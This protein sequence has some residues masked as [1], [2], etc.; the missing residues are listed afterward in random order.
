MSSRTD[1]DDA[2]ANSEGD[3]SR[4][5][6]RRRLDDQRS[7]IPTDHQ[8]QRSSSRRPPPHDG[9][10]YLPTNYMAPYSSTPRRVGDLAFADSPTGS[11]VS[12]PFEFGSRHTSVVSAQSVRDP[13]LHAALG[14]TDERSRPAGSQ[15]MKAY[16]DIVQKI[17]VLEGNFRTYG[18]S[19]RMAIEFCW[20]ELVKLITAYY[21]DYDT[22]TSVLYTELYYSNKLLGSGTIGNAGEFRVAV[23]RMLTL[24]REQVDDE[25]DSDKVEVRFAIRL[26]CSATDVYQ[27]FA[28]CPAGAAG[29][30]HPESSAAGG[31]RADDAG[32]G[33]PAI[34][35]APTTVPSGPAG[36]GEQRGSDEAA[37][38]EGPTVSTGRSGGGDSDSN[39]S[40]DV[41]IVSS[42]SIGPASGDNKVQALITDNRDDWKD[43][44]PTCEF[45]GHDPLKKDGNKGQGAWLPG[46]KYS[47]RPNQMIDVFNYY[48]RATT[49]E[50]SPEGSVLAHD[51]GVGK[52]VLYLA[53]IAVRRLVLLSRKHA[54]QFP[55]LHASEDGRCAMTG[56]PFGMQCACEKDGLSEA[57]AGLSSVG[58]NMLMVPAALVPQAVRCGDAFLEARVSFQLPTGETE[59][60][61]FLRTV[62]WAKSRPGD[63]AIESIR[64]RFVFVPDAADDL[65]AATATRVPYSEDAGQ[66]LLKKAGT[67]VRLGARREPLQI[68]STII[69]TIGRQRVSLDK[70]WRNRWSDQV[71]LRVA[72]KEARAVIQYLATYYF[73]LIVWDE[74]HQVRDTDS[75]LASVLFEITRRQQRRPLT[76]AATG[77]PFV[78]SLA[79]GTLM[80]AWTKG[81]HRKREVDGLRAQLRAA[82]SALSS[83][84]FEEAK[85]LAAPLMRGVMRRTA[86]STCLGH[87]IMIRQ[88]VT[89]ET[90]D[91]PVDAV[92]APA[93]A[94]LTT[95]V[96]RKYSKK[97]EAL[98][99]AK[100]SAV[101]IQ[102]VTS[103][104]KM[105]MDED[106]RTLDLII[107]VPGL[108]Q[109]TLDA[110][111]AG[112]PIKTTVAS[113]V[114]AIKSDKAK[115]GKGDVPRAYLKDGAVP[116]AIMTQLDTMLADCSRF[117]ALRDVCYKAYKDTQAYPEDGEAWSGFAGPKNVLI[118]TTWPFV[119]FMLQLWV[120]RNLDP[121]RFQSGLLHSGMK[122]SERLDV[123]DWFGVFADD[124]GEP[125]AKT[126]ILITTYKLGGTGLDTLKVANHLVHY[127]VHKNINDVSQ[128]S[129]R[130]DRQGQQLHSTIYFL[131]SQE[132]P[133]DQLATTVA[134]SRTG[135]F[136]AHGLVGRLASWSDEA[137]TA[138]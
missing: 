80:L 105:D 7:G 51:M 36:V 129:G 18:A 83:K 40:D 70:S 130:I 25:Q 6:S 3:Q 111:A 94:A 93:V 119:A 11:S 109:A 34:L 113:F 127:G 82:N 47:L 27:Y 137:D 56:R 121:G 78:T 32:D 77:S 117:R 23:G 134:D 19:Q 41:E 74:A 14:F 37:A 35:P 99:A 60:A 96:G 123:T 66:Q 52:T 104:T 43:W 110:T 89:E 44:P 101:D 122:E 13:L 72:E 57:I 69:L 21:P 75:K 98:I 29:A 116:D 85:P 31:D 16:Q 45:F 42:R 124:D 100:T 132:Q 28:R 115:S 39:N 133:H 97:L 108:H 125:K 65:P 17:L 24:A 1:N 118:L 81:L 95:A 10:H 76:V 64:S 48:R 2:G 73:G 54:K 15:P 107:N 22:T 112:N 102:S 38:A 84:P 63:A 58:A 68:P 87:P 9:N 62:D 91:C 103:A 4:S 67:S 90:I 92:F 71:A 55:H 136:G 20:D 59:S 8:N 50:Q 120:E 138:V 131:R 88:T 49:G 128:G 53:I 86:D 5:R 106:L 135:L 46:T 61:P 126:K 12:G 26:G 33:E 30:E 114:S 79:D